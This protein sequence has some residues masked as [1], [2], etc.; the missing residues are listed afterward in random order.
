MTTNTLEKILEVVTAQSWNQFFTAMINDFVGR[1][2]AGAAEAGKRLGTPTIPWGEAH[3]DTLFIG[4][5]LLDPSNLGADNSNGIISSRTRSGSNLP[6]YLRA[7]GSAASFTVLGNDTA[8][9]LNVNKIGVSVTTDL[10][11][12]ALTTAPTSNNTAQVNDTQLTGDT[13]SKHA[14]EVGEMY[15]DNVGTEIQD[16]VGQHIAL[17]HGASEI[18]FA[19]VKDVDTDL[20]EATLTNVYRGFF[21]DDNGD[22]LVREAM[23][24]NATLTLLNLAWVF[25]QSDGTTLDVTYRSPV[26]SKAE[27]ASPI[28]DDYWFDVNALVWKRYNGTI[29]ETI[30]RAFIGWVVM[31]G[32]NCIASRSIDF[33]KQYKEDISIDMSDLDARYIYSGGRNDHVHVYGT[34]LDFAHSRVVWDMQSDFESG[35]SEAANQLVYLYI[36]ETGLPVISEHKPY[37]RK[38]DLKGFYHPYHSWRCVGEALNDGSSDL[39]SASGLNVSIIV[40]IFTNS[41]TWYRRANLTSIEVEVVGGGG[42]GGASGYDNGSNGGTSSFGDHCSATG[43]NGGKHGENP[44]DYAAAQ[45]GIGVGGDL[46]IRG[47]AGG[48]GSRIDESRV[49]IGGL[50]G[51]ST[52]GGGGGGRHNGGNGT[53]SG[54]SGSYG[55]GGGGGAS[56]SVGIYYGGHGGAAG[57]TAYKV[58]NTGIGTTEDV[59]IGNGGSG[60]SGTGYA[61]GGSGGPGVVIVKSYIGR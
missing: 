3:V 16:R 1:N 8:L 26:W 44:G 19:Y 53:G 31:D 11:L 15:L 58:I 28:V 48:L 59:V 21:F 34:A 2:N 36:T 29:F 33:S 20:N 23:S 38:A 10:Q 12:T 22:P 27:P 7:D 52:R 6:D 49:N 43:G 9:Q 32:T 56:D 61:S 24:D 57:G 46:N 35:Q 17:K 39:V 30:N 45:G 51:S 5:T 18:I 37:E 55:G 25:L 42:G 13:L 54:G 14:G 47:Q 60:G 50:G 40:D 41:G 4:G